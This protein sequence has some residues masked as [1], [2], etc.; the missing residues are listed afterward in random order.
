MPNAI[1]E[2]QCHCGRP[3]GRRVIQREGKE[4]SNERIGGLCSKATASSKE[5]ATQ[6]ADQLTKQTDMSTQLFS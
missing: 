4:E 3:R 1:I 6:Q 2:D 5:N